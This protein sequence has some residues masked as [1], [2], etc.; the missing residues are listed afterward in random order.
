MCLNYSFKIQLSGTYQA[1][2]PKEAMD[3][4]KTAET[5]EGIPQT[6]EENSLERDQRVEE[7]T[8]KDSK[9]VDEETQEVAEFLASNMSREEPAQDELMEFSTGFDLNIEDFNFHFYN[10]MFQDSQEITEH[11]QE[12]VEP[13]V[14]KVEV[15]VVEP[16]VQNVQ[17]DETIQ[18]N[19]NVQVLENAPTAQ[20]AQTVDQNAQGAEQNVQLFADQNVDQNASNELVLSADLVLLAL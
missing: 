5:H 16:E 10:E 13:E 1:S 15:Y 17:V 4:E 8:E 11:A 18:V 7:N 19:E 2:L 9:N 20:K 3:I 12:T 6:A 14:Q